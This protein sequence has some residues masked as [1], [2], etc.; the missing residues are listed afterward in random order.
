MLQIALFYSFSWLMDIQAS[1]MVI[2]SSVDGHSGFF[3]VLVTVNSAAMNTGVLVS[4]GSC[5]SPDRCLVMGICI[6]AYAGSYGSSVFRLLRNL[7]TVFH[8]G[9]TNL[10]PH[11]QCRRVPFSPHS[12][13]HLF[14]HFLMMASLT[15]VT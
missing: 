7:Y 10:H 8:S 4:F 1:E 15:D 6:Y 3:H 11:Q 5:F 12:L 13:Q 2:H 9:C 14:V